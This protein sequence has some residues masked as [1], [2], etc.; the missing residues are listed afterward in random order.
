MNRHVSYA[1]IS[2]E[3]VRTLAKLLIAKQH[4]L[5]EFEQNMM[6]GDKRMGHSIS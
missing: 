2:C 3:L 1:L 4:K 5:L 6:L